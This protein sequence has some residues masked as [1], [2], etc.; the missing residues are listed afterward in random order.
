MT[1]PRPDPIEN[2]QDIIEKFGG[3]RPMASKI[4]VAVTTV[5]GWKKRNV[6]PGNRKDAVVA[7]AKEHDIDVSSFFPDAPKVVE[8][9]VIQPVTK[10]SEIVAPTVTA[11][12]E[13]PVIEEKPAVKKL[14]D[15]EFTAKKKEEKPQSTDFTE[16]VVETEKKAITKSVLIVVALVILVVGMLVGLLWPEYERYDAR[17]NRINSLEGEVSSIKKQQSAFKGLV[18]ENWSEQLAN[19]KKQID[20]TKKS[21]EKTLQAATNLS[22]DFVKDPSIE[23]RV[24]QL[25]GYV[26]EIAGEEAFY[27]L[28]T[29][30]EKMRDTVLGKQ[31][32]NDSAEELMAIF[33]GVN[34]QDDSKAENEGYVNNILGSAR[35]QSESL[36]QT[37]E[38]VPETELRAAAM[39]FGLTQLR[40]S[41][42]RKDASFD[43]DLALMMNMVGD[44]NPELKAALQKLAP[45]SKTG[46]LSAKG[47]TDEFKTLTGE[48]VAA[49]LSGEDV[50]IGEKATARMNEILKVEKEGELVTGTETQVTVNKAE[51]MMQS[52]QWTQ[53]VKHLKS[54]LKSKE[55][56]PLR[57]WI[58]K[59][60]GAL[61]SRKA[62]KIIDKTIEMS[63]GKGLLGGSQLLNADEQ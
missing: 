13:A 24:E 49:S 28:M 38:G 26:S 31:T 7:A 51:K 10:E 18:P 6:I 23:R 1:K 5:Q 55:L 12:P 16:L 39:L 34:A 50:S 44:D 41:L 9:K 29:K 32:L 2:A 35:A 61:A 46:L 17:G 27:G 30:Y 14:A 52:G 11:E 45:H 58:R 43:S 42:N 63:V 60:E 57:P 20:G 8:E 53:A 33:S 22:Q 25:Q 4:G 59:V 40:N 37:F 47:L 56:A 36:G 3:I 48:V 54:N 62:K 15:D 19:L 21:A